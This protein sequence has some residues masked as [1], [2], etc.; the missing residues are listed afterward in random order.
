M[1]G[2]EMIAET[3]KAAPPPGVLIYYGIKRNDTKI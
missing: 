2:G 1:S 3:I